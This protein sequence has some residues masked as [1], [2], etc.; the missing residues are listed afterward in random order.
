MITPGQIRAARG[1]L[2]LSQTQLAELAGVGIATVKRIEA[3]SE[4]RGA[5]STLWRIQNALEDAGIKFMAA[6]EGEGA[7]VR[8]R[9]HR[10]A[11]SK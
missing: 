9:L 7:G 8:L 4:I 11:K 10:T 6:E 1:L 2:N 5:A 3:S